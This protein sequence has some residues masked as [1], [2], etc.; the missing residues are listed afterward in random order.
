MDLQA[1]INKSINEIKSYKDQVENLS[2]EKLALDR[3]YIK[4]L[5]ECVQLEANCIK[6][7]IEIGKLKAE[8]NS[9]KTSNETMQNQLNAIKE[10]QERMALGD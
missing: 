8:V 2:V 1:E 3:Q 6:Y 7:E 5:Q 4:K 10:G 9:L